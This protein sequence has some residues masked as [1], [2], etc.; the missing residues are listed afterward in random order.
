M[1]FEMQ[2]NATTRQHQIIG[3]S[4]SE[5]QLCTSI[6]KFKASDQNSENPASEVVIRTCSNYNRGCN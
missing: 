3:T 2:W 1:N 6:S 4:I 5:T